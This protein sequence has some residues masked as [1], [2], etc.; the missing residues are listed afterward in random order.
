[1]NCFYSYYLH[2]A[3]SIATSRS[4]AS[5]LFSIR[6]TSTV[7]AGEGA[8]EWGRCNRRQCKPK[9]EGR[10][11]AALIIGKV[12][13]VALNNQARL[14]TSPLCRIPLATREYVYNCFSLLLI[15]VPSLRCLLESLSD[16]NEDTFIIIRETCTKSQ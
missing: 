5:F 8:G 14:V 10:K 16:P 9:A 15:E 12:A 11:G 1:M 7:S 2:M 13:C 4:D 6:A 3:G